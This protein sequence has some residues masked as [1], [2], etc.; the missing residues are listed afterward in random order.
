MINL[1]NL[2]LL[3]LLLSGNT[4]FAQRND[5]MRSQKNQLKINLAALVFT[6]FSLQYERQLGRKTTLAI[7]A[8]MR[9]F[10]SMPFQSLAK[11]ALNES[12]VNLDKLK[13]GAW[14]ITPELRYYVGKKGAMRGFYL[15]PYFSYRSYK[16]DLPIK[17]AN[18]TKDGIFSGNIKSYTFG[19]QIGA[20]WKIGKNLY[21][22]WWIIGPNYGSG[23]GDLTLTTALTPSEQADLIDEIETIKDDL[24]FDAIESYQVG[25]TGSNIK[26][27]GPW[28]GLRGMGFCIGYRF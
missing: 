16:S 5:S 26:I 20:Q 14:G 12:A 25:P 28:A 15:G 10:G 6:N 13:F 2:L 18:D 1:R 17:Y 4:L 23:R 9:P 11:K 27:K 19:L 3:V 7:G 22:D 8:N 21:F 24:P